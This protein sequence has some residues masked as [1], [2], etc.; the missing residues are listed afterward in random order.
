M[1]ATTF[2]V[3]LEQTLGGPGALPDGSMVALAGDEVIGFA[4]LRI[5]VTGVR[6]TA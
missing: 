5:P 1:E 4:G 3:W 2:D 6:R